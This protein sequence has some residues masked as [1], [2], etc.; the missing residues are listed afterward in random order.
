V[1]GALKQRLL[2]RDARRVALAAQEAD[3]SND[4]FSISFTGVG[5]FEVNQKSG[6]RWVRQRPS[7][8]L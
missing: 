4:F 7:C 3:A 5:Y 6:W 8:A 1:N 2:G